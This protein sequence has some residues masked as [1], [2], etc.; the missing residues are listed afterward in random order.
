MLAS[1]IA[2][3]MLQT[4]ALVPAQCSLNESQPV[5]CQVMIK[6]ED[7][8]AGY[9]FV[10]PGGDVIFAGPKINMN[11]SEVT[12]VSVRGQVV[13]A[14]GNCLRRD[15]MVGCLAY[16]GMDEISIIAKVD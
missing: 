6:F 15:D 3:F 16:V 13:E 5:A 11:S 12:A 9:A 10:L 14:R 2:A 1:I 7:G 8:M 4:S